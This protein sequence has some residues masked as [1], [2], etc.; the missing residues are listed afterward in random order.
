MESIVL[1]EL[2]T[3][4][5]K[6]NVPND[7]QHGFRKGKSCLTNLL[8][9]LEDWTENMDSSHPVDVI[10]LDMAKAFDK[11]PHQ[12]LV[13]KMRWCGISG[14][15]LGWL[16]D[17]LSDRKMRVCVKGEFSEWFLVTCSVPQGT[18]GG[19]C[20]FSIYI[21]D[22]PEYVRNKLIQFADDMKLWRTV[23]SVEDQ[24][25][26]QADLDSLNQWSNEWLMKF[27]AK[28]C[29]VLHL[30]QNNLKLNYFMD[31]SGSPKQLEDST[32]E[33]DLGVLISK[34]LK[35]T[36]QCLKAAQKANRVLG[37][38]KRTFKRLDEETLKLLYCS[39][40]RPQMEFC[41]QAW[42]PYYKKDIEILEKV[43][44]RATKLVPRLKNNSY[45]ERLDILN[46][47][48]LEQRR[49]RGDLIKTFKILTARENINSEFF[50][51]RN[52]NRLR[53]NSAKLFQKRS[54]LLVRSN[55]FSQRVVKYWNAL[56][57]NVVEAPS[58]STFKKRIDEYW[59]IQ[60]WDEIQAACRWLPIN[61]P[62]NQVSK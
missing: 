39:Y 43:Q 48:R 50:F 60:T 45:E 52:P 42:S 1:D 30:G 24:Q 41:I 49:L 54:R 58:I 21:D 10:Y 47:Y 11:V 27:N 6:L 12:R 40:V 36:Q 8:V 56:P 35:P 17:F 23:Q 22:L 20:Q 31:E 38:I 59:R 34:D 9:C 55:F 16:S 53:G 3:H 57:N 4:L 26:L 32:V 51:T 62:S 7:H 2:K 13:R 61:Q 44:R 29:K 46:I 14:N 15:V 25:S 28:K 5:E 37:M 19:P 33:R 18:I